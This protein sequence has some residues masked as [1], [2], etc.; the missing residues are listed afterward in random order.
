M[1]WSIKILVRYLARF[2]VTSFST[3]DILTLCTI[4]PHNSIKD[5]LLNLIE[6]TFK[7]T[8]KKERMLCLAC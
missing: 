2:R 7:N 1:F 8:F 5:R 3:Y 4:L 6:G